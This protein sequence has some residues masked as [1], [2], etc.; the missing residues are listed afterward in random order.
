MSLRE[1][2]NETTWKVYRLVH[3]TTFWVCLVIAVCVSGAITVLI[4]K[5]DDIVYNRVMKSPNIANCKDFLNWHSSSE[6]A[7]EISEILNTLLIQKE[8]DDFK[9]AWYANTLEGCNQF[10]ECHP[11]SRFEPNIKELI[12]K[13]K[14]DKAC[15][16]DLVSDYNDF[17]R[18]CPG[19]KYEKEVNSILK[20]KEVKFYE[21][22]VNV[23]N[24][25]LS[26]SQLNEYLNSF[27]NGRYT[28]QVNNKLRILDD[29][30][31]YK[32][33]VSTNSKDSWTRYLEQFPQGRYAAKARAKIGE[34]EEMEKC[35]NNSLSN[36]S[37]PYAKYYGRNCSYNGLRPAVTV[38]AS[39]YSDVVVIVRY[40]N[41]NGAVAGHVYVRKNCS[42]TI[43]L[44]ENRYYQVFFYYGSG[45]YPKK[46]MTGGVKGG[47]LH[48]ESFSKDGSP[49]YLRYG[50]MLTYTLT[51]QIGGNFSTSGSNKNEV[52]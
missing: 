1:Y 14:Y 16:S 15:Q 4:I 28:T 44:P 51:Q 35:W 25:S 29:E 52:F 42:S 5:S 43:Y 6:H 33:A 39:A 19:S 7:P 12:V 2:Y 41:S 37:Q 48:N 49:I 38:N 21:T 50:D 22:Y 20:K 32:S 34:F 11:E 36:G 17:L 46:D 30:D 10:L 8:E 47:F 31:A 23:S 18:D 27:P 13:I 24:S 3:K 26:R 40:N 45:W 9:K